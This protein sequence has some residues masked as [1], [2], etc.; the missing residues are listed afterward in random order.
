MKAKTLSDILKKGDRVAVSNITGREA[1]KVSIVSQRYC[2]NIVAGWALGKAGQT[3]EVP[4]VG[5][6]PVFGQ[7]DELMAAFPDHKKPNKVIVYSP[8]DAVYGDVKEVL[9]HGRE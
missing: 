1:S 3:V 8:P 4:S 2:G 9:E 6:I 5:P 7:F